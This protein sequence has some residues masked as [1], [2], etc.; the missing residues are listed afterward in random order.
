[1]AKHRIAAR[2]DTS[3]DLSSAGEPHDLAGATGSSRGLA[4][5]RRSRISAYAA[6][7]LVASAALVSGLTAASHSGQ[8][9]NPD[10]SA[11]TMPSDQSGSRAG[12]TGE[13]AA[14]VGG[15]PGS[16]GTWTQVFGDE[17]D[18]SHINTAN[19]RSNRYGNAGPNG[20]FNP[21]IEGQYFSPRNVTVSDGHALLTVRPEPATVEGVSYT[22]SSGCLSSEGLFALQDGDYVEARIRVPT[23]HGLWPAFWTIPPGQWP[24]E[25]D[26]FEFFDTAKESRPSAVYHPAD[27]QELE[28]GGI[29]VYG[30]PSVDYRD[31]WH[32]YGMLR[33]G[34]KI[35]MYAD[36]VPY[37]EAGVPTGADALPQFLIINLSMYAGYAPVPGTEMRIDWVRA[38][39]RE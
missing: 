4:R 5:R 21:H 29:T 7:V 19:W 25:I 14:P 26:I 3:D 2:V 35:V 11:P 23:G 31:S 24:P 28:D 32:T 12:G 33:S 13:S 37:P 8:P 1:V 34:G 20:A 6:S 30:D 39:R 17:F 15:P 10:D 16:A 18:G 38:W 9:S 27:Y 22:H 36:G